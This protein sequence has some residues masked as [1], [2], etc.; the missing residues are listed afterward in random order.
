MKTERIVIKC[1]KDL[2]IEF[3]EFAAKYKDQEVALKALL[4]CAKGKGYILR[5]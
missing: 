5:V 2:K 3:R 4:E 1:C